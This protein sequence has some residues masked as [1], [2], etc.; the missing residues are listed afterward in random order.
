MLR[1][2]NVSWIQIVYTDN[3]SRFLEHFYLGSVSTMGLFSRRET[4]KSVMN[5]GVL[6]GLVLILSGFSASPKSPVEGG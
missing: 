3:G 2:C 5:W 6:A 4:M 1:D